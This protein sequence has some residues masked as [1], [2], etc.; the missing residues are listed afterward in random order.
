LPEFQALSLE[1][2]GEGEKRR[3]KR[4][5][6]RVVTAPSLQS[7]G[8]ADDGTFWELIVADQARFEADGT[9]TTSEPPDLQLRVD[10]ESG[11]LSVLEHDGNTFRDYAAWAAARRGWL[12]AAALVMSTPEWHAKAAHVRSAAEARE[13]GAELGLV[14]GQEPRPGCAAGTANCRYSLS[15]I[16]TCGACGGGFWADF[17]VDLAR[18]TLFVSSFELPASLPYGTWRQQFRAQLRATPERGYGAL[19]DPE[20][21]FPTLRTGDG[22]FGY[23]ASR[24]STATRVVAAALASGGFSLVRSERYGAGFALYVVQ[25]LAPSVPRTSPL[26]GWGAELV[27]GNGGHACEVVVEGSSERFQ[28]DRH[29]LEGDAGGVYVFV[30]GAFHP[31]LEPEP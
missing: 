10:A 1:E 22:T 2:T 8:E 11:A 24:P 6:V 29:V 3:K 16:R 27:R 9:L 18:Q 30:D 17:E 23:G 13:L 5:V 19:L 26:R 4:P 20:Q 15:A 12:R 7:K 14:F 25:P 21:A 31:W 28:F